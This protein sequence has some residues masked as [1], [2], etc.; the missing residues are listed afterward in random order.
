MHGNEVS[1]LMCSPDWKSFKLNAYIL[2]P[3]IETD[4]LSLVGDIS[5]APLQTK[6]GNGLENC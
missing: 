5:L 6:G 2:R 3:T 1:R 4:H